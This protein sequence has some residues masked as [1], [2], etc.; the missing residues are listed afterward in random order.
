MDH[1]TI[2]LSLLFPTTSLH[3]LHLAV[4]A[5]VPAPL[6]RLTEFSLTFFTQTTHCPC[7]VLH[8]VPST[9]QASSLS[10]CS[11][12]YT[13]PLCILSSHPPQLIPCCLSPTSHTPLT[14]LP[15]PSGSPPSMLCAH[16]SC[17]IFYS[18]CEM[19]QSS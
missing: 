8:S 11:V 16:T 13:P 2:S 4:L 12:A 9:P 3:T 7:R 6:S 18:A 5:L 10:Q 14:I 15:T 1:S 17:C 19:K